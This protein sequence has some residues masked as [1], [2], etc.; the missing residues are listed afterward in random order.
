[1]KSKIIAL[2]VALLL[3]LGM[4]LSSSVIAGAVAPFPGDKVLDEGPDPV[5]IGKA[6]PTTS[7]TQSI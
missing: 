1:M 6:T 2:E 3:V 7:Y 5:G 4:G